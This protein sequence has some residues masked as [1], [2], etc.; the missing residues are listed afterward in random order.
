M[1]IGHPSTVE[2]LAF[3]LV[4]TGLRELLAPKLLKCGMNLGRLITRALSPTRTTSQRQ[5]LGGSFPVG[6]RVQDVLV[7]RRRRG[8]G[9]RRGVK[10]WRLGGRGYRV[11][12]PGGGFRR[13]GS[14]QGGTWGMVG[15]QGLWFGSGPRPG[16]GKGSR[17]VVWLR[18]ASGARQGLQVRGLAQGRVWGQAGAQASWLEVG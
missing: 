15:A 7:A 12:V 6:G 18:V 11:V 10:T 8:E 13:A 17:F 9:R 5:N 14:R 16:P 3:S 2:S 4:R 1:D